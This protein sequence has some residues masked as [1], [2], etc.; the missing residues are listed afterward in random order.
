MRVNLGDAGRGAMSYCLSVCCRY[1]RRSAYACA[2][3]TRDPKMS[4]F[5]VRDIINSKQHRNL[6]LLPGLSTTSP[7]SPKTSSRIHEVILS[8]GIVPTSASGGGRRRRDSQSEFPTPRRALAS[9]EAC[10]MIVIKPDPTGH[11]LCASGGVSQFPWAEPYIW[12][13]GIIATV[14]LAG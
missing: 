13:Q 12:S 6:A 4:P 14:P 7:R 9:I 1:C 2:R 11:G 8:R 5:S 10:I 3:I